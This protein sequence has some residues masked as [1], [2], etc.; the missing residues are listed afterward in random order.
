MN[1]RNNL[2]GSEI[3]L[4]ATI[5]SIII[6]NGLNVNE[7]N[8][9]GNFFQAIGQN[10]EVLAAYLSACNSSNNNSIPTSDTS[11]NNLNYSQPF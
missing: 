8:I 5:A 4:Y 6:S 1:D 3:I 11:T 7:L 2:C 10:L 9:L